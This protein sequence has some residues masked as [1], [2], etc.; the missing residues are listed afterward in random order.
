MAKSMLVSSRVNEIQGSSHKRPRLANGQ[1]DKRTMGDYGVSANVRNVR[2]DRGVR[3]V[4][5]KEKTSS[6]VRG[7]PRLYDN[8]QREMFAQSL[9]DRGMTATQK[10]LANGGIN[11]SLTTLQNVADEFGIVFSK[12]RPRKS[13]A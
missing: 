5:E 3:R 8:D 11:V 6:G 1:L 12:G 4:P 2:S 9:R 13:A 10:W 7:R